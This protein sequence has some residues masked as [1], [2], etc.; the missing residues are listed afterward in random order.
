MM[1]WVDDVERRRGEHHL[2]MAET[3][4]A[5]ERP[6]IA[7]QARARAE[8]QVPPMTPEQRRTLC[9]S[10]YRE[11]LVKAKATKARAPEAKA[12]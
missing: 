9:L 10:T 1:E 7:E 5:L 2:V 11:P 4:E 12:T 6:D 8:K 3:F